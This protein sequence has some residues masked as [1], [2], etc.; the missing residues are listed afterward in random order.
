MT[1]LIVTSSPFSSTYGGGEAYVKNQVDELARQGI[2]PAIA[3]PGERTQSSDTYKGCTLYTFEEAEVEKDFKVLYTL[4][5]QTKPDIVHAHGFKAS[6]ALACKSKNIPCV[7]TAHHG[8]ILCPAG[9]LLNYKDQICHIRANP[10]DC[11][12]CVLKNTR[13]GISVWPVIK[14]VPL[15]VRLFVGKL[16]QKLP[17]IYY[18]TPTSQASLTIR[19]KLLNWRLI[20]TNA[21]VLIAP[22]FAIAESMKLNGA[23]PEKIVV[24]PHGIPIPTVRISNKINKRVAGSLVKFFYVGRISHVKGV[25]VMLQAFN[26][27]KSNG[28]L[29]IIG[30][31]GNNNERRYMQNLQKQYANNDTIHWHGKLAP[32]EVEAMTSQYDIMVHPAIFLEV[33]GL[34]I[35][36]ALSMG[37]PV[38]ATRCGGAEMQIEEG[39]NGWLVEPNCIKALN[40]VMEKIIDRP[41][42]IPNDREEISNQVVKIEDHIK[43]LIRL[44]DEYK[45]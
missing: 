14:N 24:L 34:S 36:E 17:F 13:G 30:G 45:N 22:S 9:T 42:E 7:V 8:G 31:A 32:K 38:I 25:H 16:I 35:A 15:P 20:Y 37:K 28:E 21:S 23:P 26:Q 41:D 3:S 5:D 12:P 44:Y 27:I 43:R 6:F 39:K 10:K 1:I 4:L 11:L 18:I 19:D 33:F 2:F 29:H 40:W